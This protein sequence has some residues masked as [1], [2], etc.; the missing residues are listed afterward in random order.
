[1]CSGNAKCR[2][3]PRAD[4]RIAEGRSLS[5]CRRTF[6]LSFQ[7]ISKALFRRHSLSFQLI[8]KAFSV[9]LNF[10]GISNFCYR[11][12]FFRTR[13]LSNTLGRTVLLFS[14]TTDISTTH[15]DLLH[16]FSRHDIYHPKFKSSGCS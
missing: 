10:E 8:S 15:P 5:S 9:P 7:L 1:M 4:R 16:L 11:S 6:S 13:F 2:N 3:A 14:L 12:L